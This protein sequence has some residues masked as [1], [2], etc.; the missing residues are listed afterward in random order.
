MTTQTG[1]PVL[2]IR[3][4]SKMFGQRTAVSELD[5]SL[6]APGVY[7][8][9]GPNGAGKTTTFKLISGLLTPSSGSIHLSGISVQTDTA[10][11]MKQLG[12]MFDVPAFYPYLSATENLAIFAIWSDGLGR[13]RI[14]QLLDLVGL[15]GARGKKVADFSWGM[16]R[17]LGIAAALLSD[18]ALILLDEPTNG[19]DP[20]GIAD[21]RRM[22]PELAWQEKRLILLSSHR[23]EEV[24]QICDHVTI[25]NHGSIVAAGKPAALTEGTPRI[26]VTCVD[27]ARASALL[28]DSASITSVKQTGADCLLINSVDMSAGEVNSFLVN[29]DIQVDQVVVRGES[30]EDVFFRLTGAGE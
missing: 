16:K 30:L 28:A 27:I 26:E 29:H 13:G 21:I 17:R 6:S 10:L 9:L 8:F 4:L 2:L 14:D 5:L 11:A 1:M 24:E 12:I 23:M 22:L 15:S 25:I 3:K 18:P 7:G 19:L 20:G